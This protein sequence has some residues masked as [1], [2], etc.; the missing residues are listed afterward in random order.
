MGSDGRYVSEIITVSTGENIR[1]CL[2][3]IGKGTPFISLLELRPL[4]DY[5][6]PFANGSQSLVAQNRWNYGVED[7]LR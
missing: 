4:P 2:V 3:N 5:L 6:Y 7:Q 1:M